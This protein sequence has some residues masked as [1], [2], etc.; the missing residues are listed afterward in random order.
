MQHLDARYQEARSLLHGD[1]EDSLPEELYQHV[2]S[3]NNQLNVLE[4]KHTET[5]QENV[6][7]KRRCKELE[8]Y[9]TKT[10]KDM[11]AIREKSQEQKLSTDVTY[12]ERIAVMS[13]RERK[14]QEELRTLRSN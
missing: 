2:L 6:E 7:L 3:L 9:Y 1:K 11:E 14:L 8:I 13:R 4:R 12:A 10:T 5:K